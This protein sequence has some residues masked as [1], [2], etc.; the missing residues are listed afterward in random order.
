MGKTVFDCDLF[1]VAQK[2]PHVHGEDTGFYWALSLLS[3][4]LKAE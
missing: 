1:K 3:V 4:F 2:H